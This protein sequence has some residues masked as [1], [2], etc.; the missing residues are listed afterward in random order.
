MNDNNL[1]LAREAQDWFARLHATPG[2]IDPATLADLEVWLAASPDH[3]RAYDK[4]DRVYGKLSV[5]GGS[6]RHGIAKRSRRTRNPSVNWV[7]LGA[8]AATIAALVYIATGNAIRSPE[9]NQEIAS[10]A[11]LEPLETKRGEIRKFTLADGSIATLDTDSKIEVSMTPE[12][13]R[14]RLSQ[15]RARLSVVTDTRPFTIEAGTGEIVTK[16]AQFDVGF[17]EHRGVS[18][19]LISGNPLNERLVVDQIGQC[20]KCDFPAREFRCHQSI[21]FADIGYIFTVCEEL[22]AQ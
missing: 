1:N 5:L 10:A 16:A 19:Q 20:S 3:K 4:V 13:R 18:V 22:P 7:S 2:K 14:L 17:E 15:G 12:S 8:I 9:R 21:V 6:E 11:K